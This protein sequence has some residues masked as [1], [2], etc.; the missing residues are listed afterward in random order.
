MI[1][2][3]RGHWRTVC[4]RHG[5]NE[6]IVTDD[7]ERGAKLTAFVVYLVDETLLAFTTIE[8]YVWGL[9]AW[10]EMQRQADPIGGLMLWERLM[11]SVE[12]LTFV[13][14]V[15]RRPVPLHVLK[16]TL[17]RIRL[18]IFA[19]VQMAFLIVILLFTF[20]RSE[21]PLPDAVAGENGFDPE[22]HW[23]VHD[24]LVIAMQALTGASTALF[25]ARS[26]KTKTDPLLRRPQA[27]GDGSEPY[28]QDYQYIGDVPDTV[29]SIMKWYLRLQGFHRRARPPNDPF[30]VQ[31][32][33]PVNVVPLTYSD[34]LSVFRVVLNRGCADS[35][36]Y[37]FHGLRVEGYNLAKRVAG[38]EL[39]VA[40][41]GWKSK[42][43][44]AASRRYGEYDVLTDVAPLAALM[45]GAP[46]P[47]PPPVVPRP[48]KQRTVR[49]SAAPAAARPVDN[50]AAS[51]VNDNTAVSPAVTRRRGKGRSP[52]SA[53]SATR[54]GRSASRGGR[55]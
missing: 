3:A 28:S 1:D 16:Q 17:E 36:A 35:Q 52:A 34:A 45:V 44:G 49:V 7:P 51:G 4:D 39:T 23:Q 50:G 22:Y 2:A 37:G 30:F 41:G 43:L 33:D 8:H 48:R 55:R 13:P 5:W 29:F 11:A 25:R 14:S 18:D 6:L 31:D 27:R 54:G 19:E 12:V 21:T 26:K 24:L 9:R 53:P 15:P 20:S 46:A 38:V 47:L 40:H 32:V 42:D 10:L